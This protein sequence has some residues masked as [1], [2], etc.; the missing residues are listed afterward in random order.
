MQKATDAVES[1]KRLFADREWSVDEATADPGDFTKFSV[2]G[3]KTK[4]GVAVA[5][6]FCEKLDDAAWA[7][8]PVPPPPHAIVVHRAEKL[9]AASN[10]GFLAHAQQANM[11]VEL[12]TLDELVRPYVDQKIVP[13]HRRITATER[14]ELI[15]HEGSWDLVQQNLE[16]V[17]RVTDGK[18]E[19]VCK[20][21]DFRVGEVIAIEPLGP[22]PLPLFVVIV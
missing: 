17:M 10:R 13:K 11:R 4:T 22:Y 15:E 16:R 7:A 8:M 3:K 1:L 2:R 6:V 19:P 12:F 18:A 9:N 20:W 5:A 14:A 21:Y